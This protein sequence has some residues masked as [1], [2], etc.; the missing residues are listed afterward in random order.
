MPDLFISELMQ[1]LAT[2]KRYPKY[3]FERRIDA[4]IGFFLPAV[5]SAKYDFQTD[6]IW[7]EFPVRAHDEK[8][9]SS[10]IDYACYDNK[11]GSL[12]FVELKTERA[13][14]KYDQIVYYQSAMERNLK[15]HIKDIEWIASGSKQK[16]KYEFLLQQL[17]SIQEPRRIFGI[18]LAPAN[19][20]HAFWK[21]IDS[22]PRTGKFDNQ[23]LRESWEFLSLEE[24]ACS[25]IVTQHHGAWQI[26]KKS[27]VEAVAEI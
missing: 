9:L 27:L 12:S 13:S 21:S 10:N 18:Y 6:Y 24:F 4:F 3:Q 23:K 2:F 25:E 11:H 15:Q 16:S 17:R 7:P 5:L 22:I 19:A 20:E 26:V 14:V 8:R 1:Q